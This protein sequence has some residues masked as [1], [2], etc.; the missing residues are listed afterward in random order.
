MPGWAGSS[1]PVPGTLGHQKQPYQE[2]QPQI[3]EGYDTVCQVFPHPASHVAHM[4]TLEGMQ[5]QLYCSHLQTGTTEDT[6][7]VLARG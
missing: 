3:F 6:H 5:S 2:P 7:C 1:P 4:S